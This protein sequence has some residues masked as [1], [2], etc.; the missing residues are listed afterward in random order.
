MECYECARCRGYSDT[1][2]RSYSFPVIKFYQKEI[3]GDLN[4]FPTITYC[5][6]VILIGVTT[7]MCIP[8]FV[9]S[10]MGELQLCLQI[11]S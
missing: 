2:L 3:R 8:G 7:H 4:G 10:I 1:V 11:I 6:P 5:I 9:H